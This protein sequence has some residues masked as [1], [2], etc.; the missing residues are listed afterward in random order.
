MHFTHLKTEGCTHSNLKPSPYYLRLTS[1]YVSHYN[2][3]DSSMQASKSEHRAD[4]LLLAPQ[5]KHN[6]TAFII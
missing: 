4:V 1:C 3:Y 6:S 2:M 5:V